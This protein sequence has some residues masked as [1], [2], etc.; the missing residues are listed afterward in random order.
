M[1]ARWV[2]RIADYEQATT[3]LRALARKLGIIPYLSRVRA[4]A[5]RVRGAAHYEAKFERAIMDQVRPGD[6]VWDVG[7]N[8]GLY[9]TRL[10]GAVGDS[11]RVI[12]FEPSPACFA[13]LQ[14][15]TSACANVQLLQSALSDAAGEACLSVTDDPTTG[16]LFAASGANTVQVPVA[17]GDE[18]IASGRA[19]APAVLKID[20]EGFEEEVLRGLTRT[21]QD[22]RCRAVLCEVHFGILDARGQRQAPTRI[23]ALLRQCGFNTRWVDASHLSAT[24]MERA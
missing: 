4:L 23:T 11:G 5:N 19:P 2:F 9:T 3:E 21:L 15:A 6:V 17:V 24:R 10:S 13:Q 16:S 14:R 20:V 12:A 8:V 22:A 1:E 7:A 18:L